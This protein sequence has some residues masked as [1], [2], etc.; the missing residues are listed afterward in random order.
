[1]ISTTFCSSG[2]MKKG[3][4]IPVTISGLQD[5]TIFL[6][7]HMGDKQYIKDTTRLDK[8]GYAVFSGEETL[9]QG[10]Y[11]IVL[12]GKQYFEVLMSADQ[13]YSVSCSYTDYFNTLKFS[14]SDENSAFTAYQKQW[15]GM[16]KKATSINKRLQNNRQNTDS[17]RILS[18]MQKKQEGSMKSYLHS[19]IKENNGN[20]LSVLVKAML[21][22]EVPAISVPQGSRNPDSLKWV[23]N[24][25]YNKDHFFDNIDI[26][27]ERLLRTPILQARLNSFFA[28]V[29]IQSPDSIS[30]EIDKIIGKVK[31]NYKVFQFVSV[32]LFNHFRESEIMGHDAIVVK[33]ADEIYL[34]GKA[35]W[36]S[37]DFKDDLR[38]QVDRIRP[39]L[40]GVRAHDLVMNSYKGIFVSLYDIEKDFTI[41]YFW[42]PDCGHCAEATPKLKAL[43]DKIRN[44]NVEVFSVCT[45]G[46]KAKWEKY[47][48]EHKLDW[49]NGWDPERRS[50]F[51]YYY[52]VESTPMIYILDR[53]KKIIAKKLSVDDIGSFID[54]YRKYFQK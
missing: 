19:V 17:L 9:P 8:K 4:E 28:N 42:E 36:V 31:D 20:L 41:L 34:T 53:D 1:M 40:I 39:N 16:Q 49:I 21:P 50:N 27:D 29:V 3:Y 35:D 7:Y 15:V 23:L 51:G 44:Q 46:E 52:N 11:M 12:P 47:I 43:Y 18:E 14:G 33:L 45:T 30:K 32:Y 13:H 2:Q 24:Y 48:E 10:I 5:S 6:A 22:V 37:K 54:N 25:D 26:N 38:K